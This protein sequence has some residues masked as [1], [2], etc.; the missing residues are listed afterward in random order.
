MQADILQEKKI[1]NVFRK[2]SYRLLKKKLANY[3]SYSDVS[4][5]KYLDL[6]N[7]QSEEVYVT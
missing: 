5:M 4:I 3:L 2:C 7:L 6:G 1:S